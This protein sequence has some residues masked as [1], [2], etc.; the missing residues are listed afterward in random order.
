MASAGISASSDFRTV[1]R[2]RPIIASSCEP[3]PLQPA[4]FMN[5]SAAITIRCCDN[6]CMRFFGM[7]AGGL[8]A[9]TLNILFQVCFGA[10]AIPRARLATRLRDFATN[11]YE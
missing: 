4:L 11:R 9:Q 6:A 10:F 1:P 5:A 2:A 7:Q 3:Q 8:A